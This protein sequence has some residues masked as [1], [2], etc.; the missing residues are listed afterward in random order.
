[1][2]K[3]KGNFITLRDLLQ[4]HGSDVARAALL[5]SAE[6]LRDPDWRTK[7]VRDM[8]G[9]L[10]AFASLVKGLASEPTRGEGMKPIDHWLLS[11]MQGHIERTTQAFE[12]LETRSAFQAGFFDVWKDVRWYLRRGRPNKEV[13]IRV[14]RQWIRLV[15]PYIPALSEELWRT[16]GGE[17]YVSL[18][19]W[20]KA[21]KSLVSK[22]AEA[23]E[24]LVKQTLED[25]ENILKVTG[26]RPAK[27]YLYTSP[28]WKWEVI[29][30]VPGMK[31]L[32]AAEIIKKAMQINEVRRHGKEAVKYITALTK[33]PVQEEIVEIDEKTVL[34]KA[35]EF[36]QEEFGCPVEVYDAEDA[37]HDPMNKRR[38]AKPL[39]PAIYVESS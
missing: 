17:G 33:E 1:M 26:A 29:K 24:E 37:A 14:L 39:K 10:R 4:Q 12:N 38:Q 31:G 5:Y 32:A 22:E 16:L 13:L 25:V 15:A 11:K 34:E 3:S 8:E 19:P 27:L 9:R 28:R 36:F 30:L 23:M 18:A 7:N 2:S 21:D 35:R 6:G 20:P